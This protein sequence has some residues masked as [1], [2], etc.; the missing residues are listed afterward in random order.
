MDEKRFQELTDAA[1][2]KALE[3]EGFRKELL[4]DANATIK[5]E[6]GEELPKKVTYHETTDKK[7]V[8]ILPGNEE[9]DDAILDNV[10]GGFS[11]RGSLKFDD[12]PVWSM[13]MAY[14]AFAIN[15][16]VALPSDSKS[17]A[18]EIRQ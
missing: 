4:K 8:F 17:G 13:A 12:G 5:K 6:W 18:R 7:L 9:L 2:T 16:A 11:R 15:T 10:S 1:A 3:D 14:G